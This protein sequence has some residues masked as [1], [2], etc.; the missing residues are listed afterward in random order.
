MAGMGMAALPLALFAGGMLGALYMNEKRDKRMDEFRKNNP[1]EM[2]RRKEVNR[3]AVAAEQEQRRQ[4]QAL[5]YELA[6]DNGD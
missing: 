5:A 6:R 2:A 1:E 4:Q 3:K